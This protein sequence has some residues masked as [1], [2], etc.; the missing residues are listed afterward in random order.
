MNSPP[1]TKRPSKEENLTENLCDLPLFFLG[2]AH[3][4]ASS[5]LPPSQPCGCRILLQR[6]GKVRKNP[7]T[8]TSFSELRG[9]TSP[10]WK[11]KDRSF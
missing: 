6:G 5:A 4:E 7:R 1:Y 11:G 3:S 2:P 9:R 8:N 10:R